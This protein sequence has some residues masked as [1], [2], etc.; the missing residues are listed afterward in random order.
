MA[1]VELLLTHARQESLKGEHGLALAY[2]EEAM[3]RAGDNPQ[4]KAF[5][6]LV[7]WKAGMHAPAI[8]SLVAALEH[9]PGHPELGVALLDCYAQ[10]GLPR[11][12]LQ[13]AAVMSAETLGN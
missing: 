9:F 6:G 1:D 11:K 7:C 13:A 3:A 5:H 4:V 8:R 10:F 2:S 12:A